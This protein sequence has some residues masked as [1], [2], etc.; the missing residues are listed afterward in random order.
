MDNETLKNVWTEKYQ[1]V[2]A[3]LSKL[4][5]IPA[6]ATA[7]NANIDAILKINGESLKKLI[8][9]NH[10]SLA[11]LEDIKLSC[12][13]KPEDVIIGIVKCF[14]RG[15][16]EE[17]V[18][19]DICVYNWMEKNLGYDRLQ[20]GGQG[21]I[22]A[23]A[24]ALLGIKK[25]I[26][27]TN[28]HPEIQ[29]RQFLSLNNLYGIAD[30]G[31]LQNAAE[32]S[33]TQDIPLIHWII[34][35]DKGDSFTFEGKTFICPKS[36]R[37]IATYDP[38]NMNLVMNQGF[39][40]YLNNNR[41]DYLLLSGFHPLL[42]RKNGLELI[43]N[44]VPVLKKWKEA[45]PEMIIHLEIASTQDKAIRQAIIEQ[46]APLAHSAGLN[47]RETIDLLEIT[48]QTELAAQTEKE[49]NACNLFKA[50]LF[51]KE[52]LGVPRIQLHMFGLYLTIQDDRFPYSPADNL[53]G[54]MTAAVVSSSKAY[55]GELTEY[56]HV[57][58]TLGTPVADQGL[59]EL[60]ALSEML[61]KPEL[62]ETGLCEINGYYVSAVP[63]ILIDKPKTLVGMGDT[64]SSVSLLAGR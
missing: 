64:I 8:I 5:G 20:M 22:I 3:Q 17:W 44:A 4:K 7:F 38:L 19:E 31:T 43:K 34:E 12:F 28:S 16:A 37:F 54:M 2:P 39:V 9:D 26:A 30:D 18:T 27:H 32:I 35:F 42:T 46:I 51:L 53:K 21:G 6:A 55:N 48:G 36:N 50:I 15:I 62:L 60:K 1:A 33:R 58:K 47:E 25:V 52:K 57:S 49:T 45:N 56:D 61:N 13:N 41:V 10:I 23:N 24:L 11:E 63:T 40:S 14:S 59:N 29:A